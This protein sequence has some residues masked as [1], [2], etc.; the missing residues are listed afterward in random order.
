MTTIRPAAPR[1]R[2]RL[3]EMRNALQDH[4]EASNPHIWRFTQTGR[5][6]IPDQVDEM[7]ADPDALTLIAEEEGTPIGF[8]HGRVTRREEYAP[9]AVGFI[10]LIY[11]EER[12]RRKGTG[13]GLVR[14]LTALFRSRGA[15]EANLGYIAG[16]TQ[17]ESF[18]RG[19]GFTPVRV[20]ANT[21]LDDLENR[22]AQPHG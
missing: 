1:D 5:S 22:L 18:W 10:G 14:H 11:V 3:I 17:A 2:Q 19:L 20:T 6:R 9:A 15:A 13:T 8:I 21:P 16:N 7:L 12:H 4:A